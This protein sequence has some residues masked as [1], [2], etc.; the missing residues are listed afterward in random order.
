MRPGRGARNRTMRQCQRM[1]FGK[2]NDAV[3]GPA[4]RRIEAENHAMG[5]GGSAQRYF[6][7]RCRPARRNAAEALPHLF[8]LPRRDAHVR[9]LPAVEGLQK[10]KPR[11]ALPKH[12][13]SIN[14]PARPDSHPDCWTD[15]T[16]GRTGMIETM[17]TNVSPSHSNGIHSG[18]GTAQAGRTTGWLSAR[19]SCQPLA[20]PTAAVPPAR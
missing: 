11:N 2:A 1:G 18:A 16:T 7:N 12:R 8:E 4:Q 20:A 14:V 5:I 3:A 19:S 6:K 17:M 9:N 13:A 15:L 10:Q